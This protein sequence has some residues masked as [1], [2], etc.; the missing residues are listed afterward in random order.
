MAYEF[1]RDILH[2]LG[3]PLDLSDCGQL[4]I[5]KKVVLDIVKASAGGLGRRMRRETLAL[6]SS[7]YW[8]SGRALVPAR[9]K[10]VQPFYLS[11]SI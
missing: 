9:R 6:R 4:C 8:P 3:T 10:P 1:G 5:H 2:H 11:W 7:L